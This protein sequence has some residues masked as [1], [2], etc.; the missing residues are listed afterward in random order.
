MPTQTLCSGEP[1]GTLPIEVIDATGLGNQYL[2]YTTPHIGGNV[3]L[4]TTDVLGFPLT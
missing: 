4:G 2:L 1:A 3:T